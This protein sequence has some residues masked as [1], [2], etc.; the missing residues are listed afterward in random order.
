MKPHVLLRVASALTLIHAVLHTIGGLLSA[1]PHGQEGLAVLAAMKSFR[2]EVMGSLRS[3]WDFYLG[4]GLFLSV[5]LVVIAALLWQL[6]TL[7]RTAPARAR[8]LMASL[9]ACVVAFS[10][11]SWP[12]FFVAPLVTELAIAICIGLA[13]ASARDTAQPQVA[14]EAPGGAR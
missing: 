8:P 1:P 2:F 4:F 6:A 7:A 11:L 14:A 5:T 13:Y 12:Y 3:Y 10:V 9:C